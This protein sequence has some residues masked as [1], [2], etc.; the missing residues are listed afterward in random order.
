MNDIHER[1]K[2]P[3]HLAVIIDGNRRWAKKTKKRH[4]WLGHREGALKVEKLLKWSWE[5][6]VPQLSIYML[7]TEN[8]KRSKREVEELLDIFY[9][10]LENLE[11]DE[12]G[13]LDKYE[14]K[15]RFIGDLSQLPL[16]IREVARRIMKRTAKYQKKALNLLVAYSGQFELTEVVKKLAQQAIETGKVEVT[17]KDIEDHLMV[18]A[19]VDLVIRTGGYHRLSNLLLWQAAYAELYITETLWPDFTKEELIEAF[20]WFGTVKRNFGK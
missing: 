9:E 5:L 18:N 14:V 2:V 3:N 4:L 1:I 6:N 17:A 15:V 20:K 19:P 12:S 16:R 13:I 10:Y 7:S 8:L 11:K